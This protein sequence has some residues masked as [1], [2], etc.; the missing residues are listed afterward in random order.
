VKAGK[1]RG[2]GVTSPQR[3]KSA[4]DVPAIAEALP[5]F[6]IELWWG[7]F[8]PAGLPRDV[9]ALLNK[10]I[11][12]AIGSAAMRQFME[13]E[14]ASPAGGTPEQ[15]AGAV[16]AEVQRWTQVVRQANIKVE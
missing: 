16:A 2:I 15:F 12:D 7:V 10:Q 3:V 11:N 1:V 8:G 14:G 4:P 6:S 9:L 5:D 13:A